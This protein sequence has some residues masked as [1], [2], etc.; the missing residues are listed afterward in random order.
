M[1]AVLRLLLLVSLVGC[2]NPPSGPSPAE[3]TAPAAARGELAHPPFEVRGE[4]EGLLLVWF[5]EKGAAHAASKRTDVPE[6]ARARVRV[7]AL[8]LKPEQR[9]DPSFVYV[10]DLRAPQQDGAYRVEKWAR[11]AFEAALLPEPEPPAAASAVPVILYGASWCGACR[12]AAQFLTQRGVAFVEKDIEKEPAARDELMQKARAQGV[13]TQGIPVIDVHGTL[14]AGFDPERLGSLLD[15][16]H[17]KAPG[18][19][20]T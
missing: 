17:A 10:A 14:M 13:S 16:A 12:Q 7:D 6:A 9:L 11:D 15:R 20:G 3:K 8:D 2:G 19:Q 4:L 1:R 18:D 5:D